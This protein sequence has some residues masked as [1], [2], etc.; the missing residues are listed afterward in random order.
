MTQPQHALSWHTW[1]AKA[2]WLRRRNAQL[3]EHPLCA[4]CAQRGV[5]TPAT[6]VD[7]I[8]PHNGNWTA[9]VTGALQ[10]LCKTCHDGP[11]QV[12]QHRGYLD[13]IGADGWPIDPRHPSNRYDRKRG[14]V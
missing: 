11:K 2:R 6:I 14:R 9:F 5:V 7:H 3:R 1:Y 12:E 8:A 13:D 4:M 10:S